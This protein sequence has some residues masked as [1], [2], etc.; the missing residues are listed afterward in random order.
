V[1]TSHETYHFQ[2]ETERLLDIVIHSLYTHKEIFLRELISNA[3]DALDRLRFEALTNPGLLAEGTKLEIRLEVDKAVRTL[4]VVDTGVGMS[5]EEVVANLGTIAK[6][7]TRE[8]LRQ[9]QQAGSGAAL[10]DLIG[11]FGVG[12]YSAFMVADRIVVVTR[13]AGEEAAW[14][15]E[16]DGKGTFEVTEAERPGHGTSVTLHLKSVDADNGIEDFTSSAVLSRVVKRHSDFVSYPI[17]AQVERSELPRDEDGKAIAGAV[18]VTLVKEER[19]N[20]GKPL[21]TRPQGEVTPEEYHE[22]YRHLSHDWTDPAKVVLV[23]A[24]GL[25][26]YQALL[27]IP[28]RAPLMLDPSG[29]NWGLQLFSKRVMIMEHCPSLLPSY[30]RFVAGVVDSAD[31]PLNISREMLQ[32]DR[33]I[34]AIRRFL[35]R[36]LLD[37]FAEMA[38]AEPD[39]YA[40]LWRE[41]GRLL[42]EGVSS[43]HENRDR[44]VGL[45][46]F[47]SSR[48]TSSLTS[49]QEYVDRAKPGQ[50]EIFY[51]TG[52]SRRVIESSPQLEVLLARGVEVLYLTDP[53]DELVVGWVTEFAGKKLRSVGKGEVEV[54][55]EEERRAQE[56]RLKTRETEL[57]S[58]LEA[59]K[60]RLSEH[61]KEVRLS[62]R[63]TTSP[64]CLVAGEHDMSPHL[65]RILEAA[66]AAA[67]HQKRILELN[68]EHEIVIGLQKKLADGGAEA[69]LDSAAQALLG[70]ALLAEGSPL[71]DSAA[72]TK[73]LAE[74][75]QRAL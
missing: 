20:S 9:A 21:W 36:K 29:G 38:T 53:V 73:A 42:K 34:A 4:T 59:L 54:G 46:R 55:S 39:G 7:G 67:P 60:G 28:S 10:A 62:R 63:L 1:S 72:F 27:F 65:E 75:L 58:L 40:K 12:F 11:Q 18:P 71:P 50:T 25:Q 6:S 13:R 52:E 33:H 14:R 24:E 37:A 61:V 16:S 41:L 49:L 26:E 64:A 47:E 45:L 48:D 3:S 5:R 31:L 74:L 23:K 43:D 17:L 51:L 22:F 15:W 70:Y 8:L 57:G 69:L 32:H 68:P 30:L 44:L 2:A 56:E 19:L 66:G 35:T